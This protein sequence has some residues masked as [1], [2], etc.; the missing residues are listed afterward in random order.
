MFETLNPDLTRAY[1]GRWDIS[2]IEI[3]IRLSF[4]FT[5]TIFKKFASCYGS[6]P[7]YKRLVGQN[8][9]VSFFSKI[10][11]KMWNGADFNTTIG[12][13]SFLVFK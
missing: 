9:E 13:L 11:W 4:L 2:S 7:N 12:I 8:L 5:V 10:I 3:H 1:G 6:L